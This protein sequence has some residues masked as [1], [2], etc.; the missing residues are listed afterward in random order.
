[1]SRVGAAL[2]SSRAETGEDKTDLGLCKTKELLHMQKRLGPLVP[3]GSAALSATGADIAFFSEDLAEPSRCRLP[4]KL[5]WSS[6][7]S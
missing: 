7:C 5:L 2:A 4:A 6:H 3:R 1:M